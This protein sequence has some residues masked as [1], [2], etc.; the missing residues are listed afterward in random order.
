MPPN[1]VTTLVGSGEKFKITFV[2][3]HRIPDQILWIV[4]SEWMVICL[5]SLA[6]NLNTD[7]PIHIQSRPNI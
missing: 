7:K 4:E 2:I 1:C 5:Y 3:A 6:M